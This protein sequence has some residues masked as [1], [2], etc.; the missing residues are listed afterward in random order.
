MSI[1]KTF[2]DL[3]VR[4]KLMV[5]HN[6]FFLVLSAAAYF[7]L[8]PQYK[9]Q[10]ADARERELRIITQVFQLQLPLTSV[11]GLESYDYREGTAAIVSLPDEARAFLQSN[12]AGVWKDPAK[13]RY[14]FARDPRRE[15]YRRLTIPDIIYSDSVQRAEIAL[16]LV[17]GGLYLLAVL[18][19]ELLIMP[20]YVYTPIQ[21][22]LDAD[23]ATQRGDR[24]REMIPDDAIP[25]DEI[26]Q[27]MRS[28]NATV[29]ELRGREDDLR[30]KNQMLEMQD[31]LASL[32]LM[33]ASVA[34]EMNTPLAV[35]HGSIEKMLETAPIESPAHG[36]LARMKRVTERLRKI[37]ESL[38][39]FAKARREELET[40]HLAP[41]IDEAWH[42]VAIDEKASEVSFTNSVAVD[43]R[44]TGNADRLIQVFVNLL[45]NALNAVEPGSG[46]IEVK[47]EAVRGFG[48]WQTSIRFEDNGSG[49]PPEVL[50]DI[51]D[52][53]VTTRLDSKGTGLGLTVAEG[54]ITQ[55][56][57]TISAAN[58]AEGGACLEVRLPVMRQAPVTAGAAR[59]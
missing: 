26:G 19:L 59:G 47:S 2:G 13:S 55:H 49:I 43:A 33:S 45:R 56:G 35:L 6:L 53:F 5:L 16:F 52:A 27:I 15:L 10:V 44:V 42:L 31:R 46:K 23:D 29:A 34:H 12:P 21:R 1:R 40:L 25:G 54:I 58:R 41:L 24:A 18:T 17:L 51:F 48:E 37:S 8:I 30:H 38:L 11:E 22:M 28:R 57:G 32:G 20:L 50:P 14:I 7:S 4:P 39:D 36:R 3:R 9:Q